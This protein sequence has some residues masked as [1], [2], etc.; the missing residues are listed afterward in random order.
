MSTEADVGITAFAND[1][2]GFR[3]VLKQRCARETH[4]EA[5]FAA[6]HHPAAPTKSP[7]ERQ[8]I[9]SYADFIVREIGLDGRVVE[10]RS[11]GPD[12]P[13][14]AADRAAP[15]PNPPAPLPS[16]T[17]PAIEE[18]SPQQPPPPPQ[19][20]QPQPQPPPPQAQPQE[21]ERLLADFAELTSG[22]DAALL[23]E[24]LQRAEVAEAGERRGGGGGA[25]LLAADADKLHRKVHAS[26]MH[27]MPPRLLHGLSVE[28]SQ[29]SPKKAADAWAQE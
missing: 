26:T 20:Q 27:D 13:W 23:G 1:A 19:P 4:G 21:R 10:L 29:P 2:P 15:P 25:V 6:P 28:A 16:E 3:A 11:L 17:E 7:I 12:E 24:L 9:R 18:S 14:A 22:E 8:T 5:P